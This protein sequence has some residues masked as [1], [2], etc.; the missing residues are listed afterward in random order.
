MKIGNEERPVA[1]GMNAYILYCELREC[2]I[3]DMS[4]D[5]K[6]IG[7][8]KGTGSEIRDV[9]WASLKDGARKAGQNFGF[10]NYDVGD[11]MDD[12]DQK[13]LAKFFT[14][15]AD[16]MAER[17]PAEKDPAPKKKAL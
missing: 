9:L 13:E 1:F 11:W 3:T 6:R 5:F 16:S 14:N 2:S 4:E 12:L 15:L 10:S 8:G 17:I 7:E